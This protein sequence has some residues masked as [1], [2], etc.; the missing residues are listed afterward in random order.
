ML[1]KLYMRKDELARVENL[2]EVRLYFSFGENKLI[3]LCVER[4]I[5]SPYYLAAVNFLMQMN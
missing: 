1:L 3:S 2:V 5:H 4:T